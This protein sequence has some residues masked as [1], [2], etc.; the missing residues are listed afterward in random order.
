[1]SQHT[2]LFPGHQ[3]D[4]YEFC[5]LWYVNPLKSMVGL[6]VNCWTGFSCAE[7]RTEQYWRGCVYGG[8]CCRKE[9]SDLP[10][11]S[12]SLMP[13]VPCCCTLHGSKEHQRCLD[14][15]SEAS[16]RTTFATH[17]KS[18]V[19]LNTGEKVFTTPCGREAKVSDGR[20]QVHRASFSHH[21]SLLGPRTWAMMGRDS[22]YVCGDGQGKPGAE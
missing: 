9:S 4:F 22:E 12:V 20:S 16:F 19:P 3:S 13:V 18:S 17:G 8:F 14:P 5:C 1:M 6:P 11:N 2:C 21:P 7:M 15:Q 10:P